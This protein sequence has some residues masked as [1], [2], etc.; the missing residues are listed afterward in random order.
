MPPLISSDTPGGLG[1]SPPHPPPRAQQ[2]LG[3]PR[4]APA[5]SPHTVPPPPRARSLFLLRPPSHRPREQRH[6][7]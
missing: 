1:D 4:A 2:H 3:P 6:Q 7:S 5:C